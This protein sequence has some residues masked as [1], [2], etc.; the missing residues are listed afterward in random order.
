VTMPIVDGLY[1]SLDLRR[2][3]AP[4]AE[5]T[6]TVHGSRSTPAQTV[7]RVIGVLCALGALVLVSVTGGARG[8]RR[9]LGA[10]PRAG[11]AHVGLAATW[12]LCRW[13]F[14]RVAR[15]APGRAALWTLATMFVVGAFAWG[16]TLRPEPVVA[17]IVGGVLACTVR[18][19]ERGTAAPLAIAA[20]LV[21]LA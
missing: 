21:A 11:A 18:F 2:G 6:T 16:M 17:L 9:S 1:S 5:V 20:V 10:R 13:A 3:T 12:V 7:L 14:G 8:P 15:A 4:T 19:L